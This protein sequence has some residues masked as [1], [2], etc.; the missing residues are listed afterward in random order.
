M[1]NVRSWRKV[2]SSCENNTFCETCCTWDCLNPAHQPGSHQAQNYNGYKKN[3]HKGMIGQLTRHHIHSDHLDVIL[4]LGLLTK[5]IKQTNKQKIH[6]NIAT[7]ETWQAIIPFHFFDYF[8]SLT[9]WVSEWVT[10]ITSRVS[11][12]AKN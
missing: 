5:F 11:C 1:I 7:G 3:A 10:H 8:H 12:D 2:S 6:K 4:M 9:H